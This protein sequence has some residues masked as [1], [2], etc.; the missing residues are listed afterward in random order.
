M[1][2][3]ENLFC[4]AYNKMASGSVLDI[5]LEERKPAAVDKRAVDVSKL[6][7]TDVSW[8]TLPSVLVHAM[9]QV[10]KYKTLSGAQKR[11]LV[12]DSMNLLIE[13]LDKDT[14]LEVANPVFKA[15]VPVLIDQLV[16]ATK[17][18]L[19]I[20]KRVKSCMSCCFTQ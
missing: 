9:E 16:T 1:F 7:P 12:I 19:E 18:G 8:S 20:N 5:Q 17:D 15:L 4:W 2:I 3:C 11:Q 10:E 14:E 6:L 13:R